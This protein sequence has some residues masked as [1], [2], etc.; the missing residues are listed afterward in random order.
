MNTTDTLQIGVLLMGLAGGLAIF[1]FGMNQMTDSL[2][3]LAGSR[4]KAILARLTTNRFK[5][6]FAGSLVT[7]TIQSSSVTSV[8]VIGFISAGLMSLN[9][10]MGVIMGAEIGT[11]ITAH[12]IAFKVTQYALILVAAGFAVQSLAKRDKIQ[13]YG[14]MIMG[15]GLIFFGMQLMSE[16]THP[17]RNYQPFIDLMLQIEHPLVGVLIGALFTALIQSSSATTGIVIVLASQGLISLPAGIALIFG[18]NIGTSITALLA[19]IGKPR[20]ATQTALTHVLFNLLGVL[21]WFGLIDELAIIVRVISPTASDLTGA[22]RVAAEAPRQ[23]A[24]AHTIFNVGNTLVFIWFMRPL[25]WIVRHIAP[26]PPYVEPRL[27]QPIYLEELLLETPDL[28]LDHVQLELRRLGDYTFKMVQAVLPVLFTGN[29]EDLEILTKMDD[30][31]D[32]LHAGIVAYLGKLSQEDL[33]KT[34]SERLHSYMAIAN[35]IE[36]IGDL[37]QTNLVESGYARL[38]YDLEMSEETQQILTELHNEVCWAIEQALEALETDDKK[39]AKKVKAAKSEINLLANKAENH[40]AVRL[41][42]EAPNRVTAF[43]IES[44]IIEYLKRIH[45]YARR[46]SVHSRQ[47]A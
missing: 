21:L 20:V 9:Q 33:L 10:A 35:H 7:A 19:S 45:Y 38:R 5:A 4:M 16:A 24:N 1:L 15:L 29:E 3:L 41:I 6:V 25:A 42:A 44:E 30:D 37:I 47:A 39:K 40:L 27:V 32:R 22:A 8:L 31:V 18:A 26:E 28:A 14:T 36:N 43:R 17:L 13:Q 34:Q 46:I 12:I 11:T 2:K 23:L